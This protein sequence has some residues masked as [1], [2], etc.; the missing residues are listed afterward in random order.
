MTYRTILENL[1]GR[2]MKNGKRIPGSRALVFGTRIFCGDFLLPDDI[3]ICTD[4]ADYI[5]MCN[6]REY[7]HV[8]F[9]PEKT[10]K[11]LVSEE[12]LYNYI[13]RKYGV[14]KF[15]IVVSN[16]PYDGDLHLQ[17][18]D[19]MLKMGKTCV[20]IH[21]ARWMED[22]LAQYKA[23]SA[24][25]KKFEHLKTAL[26]KIYLIKAR[27]VDNIFNILNNQDMLIGVYSNSD[28]NPKL[29]I[30]DDSDRFF[31]VLKSI[32]SYSTNVNSIGSKKEKDKVDGHR[33]E[34]KRITT[35]KNNG[36]SEWYRNCCMEI[37]S[38]FTFT[39]GYVYLPDKNG[40]M[41]KCHWASAGKVNQGAYKKDTNAPIPHSI[42]FDTVDDGN[43][44]IKLYRSNTVKNIITMLKYGPD[45]LFDFIPY[46]DPKTIKT[47]DDVL[48][49]LGI[50]EPEYRTWLK[51]EVHD[52][53]EKDFIKYNEWI[54]C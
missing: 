6:R 48:D 27:D 1:F 15:D 37:T 26:E 25:G 34:I 49:A 14:R 24:T 10:V 44:F 23:K 38:K 21:P 9:L 20:F 30:Y 45:V 29:P 35:F 43:I 39:D 51:R 17:I 19:T 42:K 32:L 18:L 13:E 53:R 31:S 3:I 8:E 33:V 16:P 40:I 46:F 47:E 7:K 52:Y 28:I 50:V 54:D 22:V 4:W 5:S 11:K 41:I 2:V 36:N 12:K